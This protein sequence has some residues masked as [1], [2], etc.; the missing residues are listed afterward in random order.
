MSSSSFAWLPFSL[1]PSLRRFLCRHFE[2]NLLLKGGVLTFL[3]RQDWDMFMA[4]WMRRNAEK[5][6]NL[7]VA[8]FILIKPP[9]SSR[10]V[11]SENTHLSLV[12]AL[13]GVLSTLLLQPTF[14]MSCDAK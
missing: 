10:L 1:L 5:D 13:T 2:V 6:H 8:I 9:S 14:S 12:L 4:Q 11:S 3:S 7:Y